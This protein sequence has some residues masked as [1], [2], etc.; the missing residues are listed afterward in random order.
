MQLGTRLGPY[1]IVDRIGAGGMGEVYRATDTRLDRSVAIKVL[2]EDLAADPERRGRFEREAKAVSSLNHPHICTLHDVGEQD[3]AY[4]LV[5]EVVEGETLESRLA[6]GRLPLD[7]AFEYAIQIADALDKAHGK[8]VVHRDLK[9]GNIM[10]TKLGVKLLDFG[11][12]KLKGDDA[13]I[14]GLSQAPTVNHSLTAAGT[15]LGTLQYIAPVQLDGKDA[16]ARTDI[17]AFG[18]VVYEMVTGKKAFEGKS[19]ASLI[20]AI[21]NTEPQPMTALQ[22]MT[23]PALDHIVR[24]CL[25]KDPA[26]RWQTAHDIS[27]QLEWISS[28]PASTGAAPSTTAKTPRRSTP[29]IAATLFFILTTAASVV[30]FVGARSVP[31]A[32]PMRFTVAMPENVRLASMVTAAGATGAARG[33]SPD[34]RTILFS[35]LDETMGKMMLYARPVDSVEARPLP[36]TE[37]ATFPI[38]SPNSDAVAYIAERKLKRVAINGGEP[39][40]HLRRSGRIGSVVW[41]RNMESRRRDPGPPGSPRRAV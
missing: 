9:P 15:I 1:Q 27:K 33:I 25:A 3:G 5:M 22:T 30:Y 34:G 21:M 26:D 7:R 17:F 20:A 18:A 12:A 28:K 10:L 32:Q 23:P 14:S 29:W 35:G 11:L 41:R 31:T 38:W 8:G 2:P 40:D 19:Q 13:P 6:R 16:D 4:Y 39:Q 24:T 37:N 36:G